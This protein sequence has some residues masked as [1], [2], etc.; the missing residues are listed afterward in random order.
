MEVIA[1]RENLINIG[2]WFGIQL[3]IIFA[4]IYGP[5]AS[6]DE[7]VLW[8]EFVKIK[9]EKEGIW[10]MMGYFNVVRRSNER[11]NSSFCLKFARDFNHFIHEVGLTDL[12]MGD[13]ILPVFII[14]T[15]N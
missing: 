8:E 14:N 11:F 10:V 9:N 4:N 1:S 3:Q 15:P 5:Q 6:S 12:K 13:I 2:H 7:K